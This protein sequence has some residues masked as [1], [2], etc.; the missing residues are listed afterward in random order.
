MIG[1]KEVNVNV[2]NAVKKNDGY[3]PCAIERNEDTKCPCKVFREET[4][5]GEL[6]PCGGYAKY[7]LDG[8]F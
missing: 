5:V 3:C 2:A 1:F 7:E 4:K 8:C 6:C